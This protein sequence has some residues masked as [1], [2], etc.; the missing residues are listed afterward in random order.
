[1]P[2]ALIKHTARFV[3]SSPAAGAVP[4][5]VAA[6]AEGVIQMMWLAKLKPLVAVA[7]ALILATAGVAVQERRQPAARAKG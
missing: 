3:T 1:M 4:V 7:A 6:L 2:S 5:A